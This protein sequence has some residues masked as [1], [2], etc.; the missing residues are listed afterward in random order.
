VT[1]DC[2]ARRP[3]LFNNIAGFACGFSTPVSP[4]RRSGM[5]RFASA[6]SQAPTQNG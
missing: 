3:E 1:C 6:S 2:F 4:S 5:P